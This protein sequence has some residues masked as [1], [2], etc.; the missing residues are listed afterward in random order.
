MSNKKL[1]SLFLI[2]CFYNSLNVSSFKLNHFP[3]QN[4]IHLKWKQQTQSLNILYSTSNTMESSSSAIASSSSAVSS[5]D[6]KSLI[7]QIPLEV[8][9]VD[10][11]VSS[12]FSI[13]PLFHIASAQARSSMVKQGLSI[14]VDWKANVQSIESK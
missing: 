4:T 6:S 9:M 8:H 7:T 5:S 2:I 1:S 10:T 11:F 14:G 12:L 13:K 3:K